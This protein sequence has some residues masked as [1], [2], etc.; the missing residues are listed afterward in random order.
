MDF[1][2]WMMMGA[3]G[4]LVLTRV[5]QARR[6]MLLRRVLAP[7]QI[8]KLLETLTEGYLRALG[9]DD[10]ERR[11]AVWLV[12]D[13]HETVLSGQLQR[14]AQDMAGLPA[15]DTRFSTLPLAL[16]MASRLP[17][18]SADFRQ[19][20]RLHAEGFATVAANGEGLS[21]RDKAFR[22]SAELL[23]FQHSCHA[24]CR[25]RGVASARLAA[26]HG[27]THAQALAA[28]SAATRDGLRAA[29]LA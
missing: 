15:A 22:L 8:E 6:V 1:A 12:M 18:P 16:P 27:T 28:A 21:A 25:S 17:L 20:V 14:L 3:L 19:V 9:E 24:F 7:Y 11:R 10:A 23:L 4:A 29:G 26:R 13:G 5:D 2:V